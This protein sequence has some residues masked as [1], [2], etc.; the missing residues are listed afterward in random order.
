MTGYMVK[1]LIPGIILQGFNFQFQAF[2]MAQHIN[3]P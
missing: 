3:K 2:I 1:W